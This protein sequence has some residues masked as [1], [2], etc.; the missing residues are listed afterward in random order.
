MNPR[1]PLTS[2]HT[3]RAI[4]GTGALLP[5]ALAACGPTDTGP[6]T[7]GAPKKLVIGFTT[8]QTGS[9]NKE[10]KSKMAPD[11]AKRPRRRIA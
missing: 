4:L 11:C 2:R 5:V 10:S 8:S 1:S 7:T 9:L 3:R 6:A